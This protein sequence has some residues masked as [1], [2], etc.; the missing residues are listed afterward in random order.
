MS[1]YFED[2]P[3]DYIKSAAM[4]WARHPWANI[5]IESGGLIVLRREM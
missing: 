3:G 1:P 5:L 4:E 2:R